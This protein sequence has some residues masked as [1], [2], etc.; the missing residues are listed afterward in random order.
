MSELRRKLL[1]LKKLLLL[2]ESLL[3]KRDPPSAKETLPKT[4]RSDL[5]FEKVPLKGDASGQR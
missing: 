4:Q 1:L 3:L 5:H 2:N